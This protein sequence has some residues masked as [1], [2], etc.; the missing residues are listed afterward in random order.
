MFKE[1]FDTNVELGKELSICALDAALLLTLLV[2]IVGEDIGLGDE[3]GVKIPMES[4]CRSE[5]G[6]VI[7]RGR[8]LEDRDEIEGVFRAGLKLTG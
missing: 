1:V 7:D 2:E 8:E 5:E 6:I 3:L 4:R